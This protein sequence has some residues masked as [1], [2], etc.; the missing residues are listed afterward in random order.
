MMAEKYTNIKAF[1]DKD[2]DSSTKISFYD[3]MEGGPGQFVGVYIP[4][5]ENWEQ[6]LKCYNTLFEWLLNAGAEYGE[7]VVVYCNNPDED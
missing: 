5:K 3:Y 7:T 4:E 6:H 2:F 1:N